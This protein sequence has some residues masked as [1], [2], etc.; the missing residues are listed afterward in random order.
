MEDYTFNPGLVYEKKTYT[1]NP[2]AQPAADTCT[3]SW[4]HVHPKLLTCAPQSS[5]TKYLRVVRVWFGFC[6]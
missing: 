2:R 4:R 6:C 1:K 5:K 3:P